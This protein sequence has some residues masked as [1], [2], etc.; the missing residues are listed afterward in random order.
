M[1]MLYAHSHFV[2]TPRQLVSCRL[3]VLFLDLVGYDTIWPVFASYDIGNARIAMAAEWLDRAGDL[4]QRVAGFSQKESQH[5]QSGVS[6][7]KVGGLLGINGNTL[8][9]QNSVGLLY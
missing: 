9:C 3:N 2:G 1:Q 4:C 8:N 6:R 5:L 7:D